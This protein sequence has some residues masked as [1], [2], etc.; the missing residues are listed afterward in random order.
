MRMALAEAAKGRGLVEPNPQVGAVIVKDEKVIAKGHHGKFGGPHAEV[1]AIRAAG[2]DAAGATLYVNLEPCAHQGKTPPCADAA[3]EAGIGEVVSAMGDPNPLTSGKGYEKLRAAGISFSEGVLEE[4]AIRL[5]APYLKLVAEGI[6]YVTAKWAMSLDGRIATTKGDS[7]WISCEQSRDRVHEL[8]GFMDAVLV[9]IG[10][11]L[12]DDPLLTARGRGPRTPARIV[13][14]SRARTPLDCT[15]LRTLDEGKVIIATAADAPE[16]K[17]EQ[18]RK[19]GVDVIVTSPQGRVNI[20][21]LF[22]HLGG[23]QMTNVLVEGG[24][25]ILGTLFDE[26]LI[27]AVKVFVSPKIIGGSD[28]PGPAIGRGVDLM[29]EALSLKQISVERIGEDVL[30]EGLTNHDH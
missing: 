29:N 15:L 23:M 16:D 26:D 5:N 4:E 11:V 18:L 19:K 1:E 9:G 21:E 25:V 14:D 7:K 3:V 2:A 28:A 22:T 24:G 6:P 27:D 13:A 17:L 8:R 10:T 30:I 20:K 12:A